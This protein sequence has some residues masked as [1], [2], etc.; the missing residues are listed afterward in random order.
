MGTILFFLTR[1][2]F[3]LFGYQFLLKE[4]GSDL[5]VTFLVAFFLSSILMFFILKWRKKKGVIFSFR[6]KTAKIL[7]T[8]ILLLFFIFYGRQTAYFIQKEFSQIPIFFIFCLLIFL[9]YLITK[10]H[11][12]SLTSTA[13]FLFYF[14]LIF[15][16]L[17]LLGGLSIINLDYLNPIFITAKPILLKSILISFLFLMPP[18]L[19]LFVLPRDI[20]HK[21]QEKKQEKV[22]FS[23]FIVGCLSILLE[24]FLMYFTLGSKL[25]SFY[26]YPLF[27][28][29]SRI[30]SF[31][32]FD[33][34]F[35]LFSFYLL[36]DSTLFLSVLFEGLRQLFS[37]KNS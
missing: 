14:F 17:L 26:E 36:I 37:K 35:F 2:C 13:F 25:T 32:I 16:L 20:I 21:K 27:A 30:S 19:F 5:I 18:I 7:G 6:T 29:V 28:L 22:F 34:M 3:S 23:Y 33:R 9:S 11:F 31:L 4:A 24:I 15:Y 1:A 10:N 8:L 12:I